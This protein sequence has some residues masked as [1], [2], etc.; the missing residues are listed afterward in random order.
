[1]WT[2]DG[3]ANGTFELLLTSGPASVSNVSSEIAENGHGFFAG[4]DSAGFGGIW[5]TDGT[6]G[7]TFE[8]AGTSQ[9]GAAEPNDLTAFDGKI[10]YATVPVILNSLKLTAQPQRKFRSRAATRVAL[11]RTR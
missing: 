9:P 10:Y 6:S 5:E 7:G 11:H 8:I 1:L 2:T 3:T 4:D